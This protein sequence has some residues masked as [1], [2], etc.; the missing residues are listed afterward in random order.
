MYDGAYKA[1]DTAQAEAAV[2]LA[3]NEDTMWFSDAGAIAHLP[4][5][6]GML[7]CLSMKGLNMSW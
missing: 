4:E 7:T 5:D 6:V 2:P 3:D 1:D